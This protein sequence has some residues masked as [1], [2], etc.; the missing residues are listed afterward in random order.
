MPVSLG[1]IPPHPLDRYDDL[2][3][4]NTAE[5]FSSVLAPKIGENLFVAAAQPYLESDG[6]QRLCALF[7]AAHSVILSVFAAPHNTAVF[8]QY[9]SSYCDSLFKV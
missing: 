4:L 6:D 1:S 7:E 2:F 8:E 9:F 5:H 3:F